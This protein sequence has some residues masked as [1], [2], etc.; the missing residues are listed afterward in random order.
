MMGEAAARVEVGQT[1]EREGGKTVTR[2][3]PC[4]CAGGVQNACVTTG[5]TRVVTPSQS[6]CDQ[7]RFSHRRTK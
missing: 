1:R 7:D 3:R 6:A 5:H 2:A 4:F